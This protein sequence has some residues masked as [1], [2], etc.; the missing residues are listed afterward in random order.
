MQKDAGGGCARTGRLTGNSRL[1]RELAR[2]RA[3]GPFARTGR[4]AV[5]D[6][7]DA[8]GGHGTLRQD[9]QADS[10]LAA[11]PGS[12]CRLLRP[13]QDGQAD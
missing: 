3:A 9:R 8:I 10:P 7:Y 11:R 6:S 5:R 1:G 13:G 2:D 4:L 12:C